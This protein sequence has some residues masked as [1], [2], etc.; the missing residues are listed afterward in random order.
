MES[1]RHHILDNSRSQPSTRVAAGL[2]TASTL[3][4]VF[5][6]RFIRVYDIDDGS[7]YLFA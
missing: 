7:G 6:S 1:R 5:L 4:E 3:T 2:K